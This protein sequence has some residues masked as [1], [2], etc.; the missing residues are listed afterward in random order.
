ME[1]DKRSAKLHT[2]QVNTDITELMISDETTQCEKNK[3]DNA[4][5]KYFC[6]CGSIL[7]GLKADQN[8]Q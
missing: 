6:K 4:K 5:G 2:K 3:D 1:V 8:T 7:P